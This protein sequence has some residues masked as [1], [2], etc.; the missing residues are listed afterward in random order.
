MGPG[1]VHCWPLVI[2]RPCVMYRYVNKST[3]LKS[4]RNKLFQKVN[5]ANGYD[6][7]LCRFDQRARL[8]FAHYLLIV[9]KSSKQTGNSSDN[10]ETE[11]TNQENDPAA[12]EKINTFD[13]DTVVH[14]TDGDLEGDHS[15][16]DSDSLSLKLIQTKPFMD[17]N[18]ILLKKR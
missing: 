3:K 16:V 12:T 9:L 17:L 14:L 18:L 2:S 6:M 1:R 13:E 10:H 5:S 4:Q 15:G 11:Q 7:K 8:H